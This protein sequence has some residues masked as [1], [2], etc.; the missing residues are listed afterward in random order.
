VKSPALDSA[1]PTLRKIAYGL[2]IPTVCIS[3]HLHPYPPF[4]IAYVR[5]RLSSPAS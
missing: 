3:S 2:A 4:L 5:N 1:G